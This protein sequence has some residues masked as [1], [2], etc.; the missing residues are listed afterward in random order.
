MIKDHELLKNIIKSGIKL[1]EFSILFKKDWR[2]NQ[3]I[4]KISKN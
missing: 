4:I 2:V 1:K 3:Y